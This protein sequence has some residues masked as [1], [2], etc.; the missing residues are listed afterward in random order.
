MEVRQIYAIMNSVTKEMLGEDVIVAEDLS[1]IVELGQQFESV[2]GLDNYVRKLPDHVGKVVFVDR[3][4]E[5]RAP[6][7]L[8]DGWEYGSIIEKIATRIPEATENEDWELTDGASYDPN[9]FHAPDV[10]GEFWNKRT[11]FEIDMSVTSK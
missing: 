4:Y 3:V 10:F 7:V 8:M 1:N 11:T 9:V 6:Q 2:V 5:G